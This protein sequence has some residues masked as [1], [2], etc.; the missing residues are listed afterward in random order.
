[1]KSATIDIINEST[2]NHFAFEALGAGAT[3]TSLLFADGFP[4][5]ICNATATAMVLVCEIDM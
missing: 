5:T 2:N 4:D 3:D 1:M